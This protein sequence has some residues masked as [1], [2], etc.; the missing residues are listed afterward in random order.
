MPAELGLPA[1]TPSETEK[2][3]ALEALAAR[4]RLTREQARA[5]AAA[6]MSATEYPRQI[7][8]PWDSD[9]DV[10]AR[11]LALVRGWSPAAIAAFL[12]RPEAVVRAALGRRRF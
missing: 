11:R 6:G 5:L 2:S 12:N 8:R 4:Q 1:G 10:L 7:E 3:E 9:D